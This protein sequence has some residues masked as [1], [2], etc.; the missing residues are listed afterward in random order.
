MWKGDGVKI[1]IFDY[2]TSNLVL[3]R[4]YSLI[5]TRHG[6]LKEN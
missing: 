3:E 2:N 1:L 4:Q 5:Y 6:K